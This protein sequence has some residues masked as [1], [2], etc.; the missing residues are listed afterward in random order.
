MI[1]LE[2]DEGVGSIY[3]K[4]LGNA[5]D[6]GYIHRDAFQKATDLTEK[7]IDADRKEKYEVA[8]RMY[9]QAIQKFL[10]VLK[11]E[12]VGTIYV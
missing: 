3:M 4:M 1:E 6:V 12:S 9:E 7:A 11:C 10:H 8:L 5:M 2:M